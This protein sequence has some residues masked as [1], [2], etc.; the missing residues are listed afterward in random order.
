MIPT[1][2]KKRPSL[3]I[4][5][6]ALGVLC[7]LVPEAA[8]ATTQFSDL[9]GFLNGEKHSLDSLPLEPYYGPAGIPAP[10]S[11]RPTPPLGA[12]TSPPGRSTRA[13]FI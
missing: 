9:L 3:K 5:L 8:L 2:L 11:V 13:S 10:S 4:M 12:A 7:F 1:V 6:A